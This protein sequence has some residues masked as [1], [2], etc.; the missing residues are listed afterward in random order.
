MTV[1]ALHQDD[2]FDFIDKLSGRHIKI[3]R[4][5]KKLTSAY[6]KAFKYIKRKN[7]LNHNTHLVEYCETN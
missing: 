2:R 4:K 3:I 7:I 1:I 6:N 5:N